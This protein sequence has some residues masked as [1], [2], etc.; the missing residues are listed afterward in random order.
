MQIFGQA[1]FFILICPFNSLN[2]LIFLR[3]SSVCFGLSSST[4]AAPFTAGEPLLY[5]KWVGDDVFNADPN[6]FCLGRILPEEDVEYRCQDDH[7][8]ARELSAT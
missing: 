1:C 7:E 2:N 6:S 3:S 4:A 8:A 5:K